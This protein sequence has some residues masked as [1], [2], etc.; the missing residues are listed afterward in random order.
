TI[1]FSDLSGYTNLSESRDPEDTHRILNRHFEIVDQIVLD[2][3]G[4]IDK[5]IGDAVM[6]LFGAPVAHG[7]DPERAVRTALAIHAAMDAMS[8]ELGEAL[9]VHI[10]IASGQVVAS[11]MGSDADR[12]Y[13]VTG[14][15]VNLAARL[16][17][18]A[19]AGQTFVSD[20]VYRGVKA[21]VGG[22]DMGEISVKG[23]DTP[24]P[25]WMLERLTG[26][27]TENASPIV[28]RQAELRQFQGAL[29][30]ARQDGSGQAIYLRAEAGIGKSRLVD[31]FRRMAGADGF[32]CHGGQ[33]LDFGQSADQSAVSALVRSMAGSA[34]GDKDDQGR[35]A[36]AV[37]NGLVD[38]NHLVFLH[39]LLNL[40]QLADMGAIYD[41]M[42]NET[43]ARGKRETLATLLTRC[44][45]RSPILMVIEDLHWAETPELAQM[46]Q[47]AA[48]AHAMPV[49]LVI[50]SR[51]ENDPVDAEWRRL[52]RPTA[53]AT[54]DLQPLG[55]DEAMALAAG[56]ANADA[57]MVQDCIARA[58]GNP[59]FL[60]QLLRLAATNGAE[61]LPSSVQSLVLARV[62]QLP[63]AD[64][65]ALQAASVLGQ[66]FLLPVL[67]SLIGKPAY[68][69]A[70]PKER[71]LV[72][73]GIDD[74]L[75]AHALIW[76]S[77]YAS[78]LRDRRRDLHVLASR[79]LADEDPML[80]AQ[81]LDRADDPGA[82]SAYQEAAQIQLEA[83]RFEEALDLLGR[84]V[85]LTDPGHD[86]FEML[87]VSGDALLELTKG[88]DA[89]EMFRAA[90]DGAE[91]AAEKCR[92]WL[93][94]VAGMRLI[95]A[96]D[97][98][99]EVL[100]LAQAVAD[101]DGGLGRE[102]SAIHY[103][104]G[105]IFF[106]M[107]NLDGCLE[108]HG[109]ALDLAIASASPEDEAKALSG[110]GDAH[111]AKG[112]MKT[113]LEHF[114]RARDLCQAH[115]L[116]RI[117]VGTLYMIAWTGLYVSG[118][119][120][121]LVSGLHAIDVSVRLGHRRGEILSRLGTSS[122]LYERDDLQGAADQA[123]K[124]LVIIDA[125]GANRFRGPA[126]AHLA[127]IAASRGDLKTAHAIMDEAWEVAQANNAN[128]VGPWVLG[129][130]AKLSDDQDKIAW[131][132]KEAEAIL[133]AGCVGHNY[134]WFYTDAMDV[135]L[136]AGNFT[137]CERYA[138]ALEAYTEPEPLPQSDFCIARGRVLAALGRNPSDKDALA[139]AVEIRAT[140]EAI[141]MVRAASALDAAIAA[142]G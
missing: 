97:D 7:N 9:T 14:H 29:N 119:E 131:A 8:A 67:Q 72:R 32:A 24:V 134:Y 117:E 27:A 88:E 105:S 68:V 93:G 20:E 33:C 94:M 4:T 52:A 63:A 1:L 123:E 80:R 53:V 55:A 120:K 71:N 78:L 106:P 118:A 126:L 122:I 17:D 19:K 103:F 101:G 135:A 60:E 90:L 23:M 69:C 109:K 31:E 114:V 15:S 36:A 26:D 74:F 50:T 34:Q 125:L 96:Y 81:H 128:F 85:E 82:P 30:T 92:A 99:L 73:Q 21:I 65:A 5:H 142:A 42:D 3:G 107:G 136:R 102:L 58:E 86:Q 57:Q 37:D 116:G 121:A 129:V 11:G 110:L 47:L 70:E 45:Q 112:R 130:L 140:A 61:S 79:I 76:E 133:E 16:V 66:H 83:F 127:R 137:E 56:F 6:A 25:V 39:D 28:G 87:C 41:A 12:E 75:F 89:I 115:G 49:V 84:A 35:A 46:A 139:Q 2:H 111:Y 64:K 138:D 13:T 100:D 132:L 44:A 43:R 10:G 18:Q 59:L 141:G 113:S 91:T 108:Q 98:A 22:Q 77:V 124:A 104:R 40:D 51:V 95:D 54:V 62:D 48:S 38:P